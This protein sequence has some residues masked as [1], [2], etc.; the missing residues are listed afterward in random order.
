MIATASSTSIRAYSTLSAPRSEAQRGLGAC[1]MGIFFG[2]AK[3]KAGGRKVS[4]GRRRGLWKSGQQGERWQHGSA[5]GY[6]GEGKSGC[7][8]KGLRRSRQTA[9]ERLSYI[10]CAMRG[11]EYHVAKYVRSARL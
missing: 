2:E 3:C 7:G 10:S 4:R 9:R 5:I 1:R 6:K 11:D 8:P